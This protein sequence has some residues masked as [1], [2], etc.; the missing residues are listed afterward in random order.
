MVFSVRVL[1]APIG[2]L[3][4]SQ[5]VE[6]QARCQDEESGAENADLESPVIGHGTQNQWKK[7]GSGNAG[8]AH[9]GTGKYAALTQAGQP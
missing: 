8:D 9:H 1:G 3:D 7:A 5:L 4:V 2:A 6:R